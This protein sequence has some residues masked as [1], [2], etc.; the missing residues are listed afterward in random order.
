MKKTK[1][2][3]NILIISIVF[4]S[5]VPVWAQG[6]GIVEKK[7]EK[8][9][10][11]KIHYITDQLELNT[12]EA[13][14][15]VPLYKEYMEK[16]NKAQKEYRIRYAMWN[17]NIDVLTDEQ[18]VEL[19]DSRIAQIQKTLDIQKEYHAR[20]KK[21]LSPLQLVKLYEA[22]KTFQKLLL[23]RIRENRHPEK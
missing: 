3:L 2:A 23:K 8:I 10:N 11:L 18:C 6:R 7:R 14:D 19:A 5:Y 4:F 12:M 9:E 20:F 15:F 16:R 17:N 22:E 21:M 1:I 13:Q